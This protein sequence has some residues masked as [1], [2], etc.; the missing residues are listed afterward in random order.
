MREAPEAADDIFV[1]FGI[2][3]V[4]GIAEVTKQSHAVLLI[5]MVGYASFLTVRGLEPATDA[6]AEARR[7]DCTHVLIDGR[8]VTV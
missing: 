2:F 4:L 8:P 7:L 6:A 1:K 5:G 3:Q